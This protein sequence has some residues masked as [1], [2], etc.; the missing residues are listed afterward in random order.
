MVEQIR[1]DV[2][3]ND[4]P[5]KT[6]LLKEMLQSPELEFIMEAH[7][8]LSAKIV[9][10][11]GFKGIWASGLSMSAALG[12]RDS[13]EASW[14]QILEVLEFMSDA[15]A[16][17]IL[18][19]GDTGWGNFNNLRR[20]VQKFNQREIAGIC[21]EDKLFPKTNS[22]IGDGQ[23][24]ADMDE[25]CGKIKAG[26][27]SQLDDDFQIV[28]RVE[29]LI[30][31]W[32]LDEALRRAEAYHEAGA[33]AILIHSKKSTADEVVAFMREWAGRSPVVLVP[34]KYYKTPTPVFDDAGA[35]MVI[36]ANHNMRAAITAMRETTNRIFRDKSLE[37]VE[38]EVVSVSDVFDL[39]GNAELADAERR[40]L[41]KKSDSSSAVILAASRGSEFGEMTEDKPKCMLEVRGQPLLRRLVDIFRAGGVRDVTVVRGHRKEAVNLP[42]IKTVDNDLYERGGEVSS[43]ACAIEALQG[44]VYISYGDILFRQYFLDLVEDTDAEIVV[45]ADAQWHERTSESADWVRDFVTCTRPYSASYLVEEPAYL[46]C[47][48][49]DIPEEGRHGEWTGLMRVSN[50]GAETLRNEID[51]IRKDGTMNGMGIPQLL[52]RL[53]EKGEKI[54]VVYVAGQWLDVDDYADLMKAGQFL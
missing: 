19:D 16:L 15:S 35:S 4:T 23:P 42:D 14:T 50:K 10:E 45:V 52:T 48:G 21:I 37:G 51:A 53:A 20:A 38:R 17:P 2:T 24:L 7:N 44:P 34:T 5:R 33:D 13:N 11:A 30:A 46:L 29:A 43:L 27:D 32:G 31:G 39:M 28:A 25:F 1:R 9:A 47:A 54:A 36:W 12:V 8:G 49:E 22:F 18:V 41:P 6:T 3:F 40:Y 26:K